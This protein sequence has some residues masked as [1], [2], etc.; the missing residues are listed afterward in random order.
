[1]TDSADS[2][3]YVS[4][5]SESKGK[6]SVSRASFNPT[7]TISNG[8]TSD[9]TPT[10]SI[11]VAGNSAT[12]VAMPS[13]TTSSYGVTK[14]SNA[15]NSISESIAATSKAVKAAYDL[16]ASKTDNVGTITGVTANA[17]LT[18]GG[19]SGTVTIGHS[20]SIDAVADEALYKLK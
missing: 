2:S 18:G 3:K 15:T 12:A 10:V 6:I 7:V 5:V 20:N 11:S 1:V 13:A 16:A 9:D 17:G 4:A 8:A 14:L 19:T